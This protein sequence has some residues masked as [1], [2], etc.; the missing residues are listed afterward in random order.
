MLFVGVPVFAGAMALSATGALG[1]YQPTQPLPPE[2]FVDMHCHVAGIGAGGSGCFVSPRMRRSFRFGFF[3]RSFGVT[4]AEVESRG[5]DIIVERLAARLA[6]SRHVGRAVVLALDGAVDAHGEIDRTRTEMYV[7]NEFV[8]A[9]AARH[10]NL[11]FGASVNP[12]RPDAL[13]RLAWAK[14][15][16][17]VLVKWLPS[18][19]HIDPADARLIPFYDRLAALRLP[20]L[21]HT[22]S[23]HSFTRADD[24]L[25]DPER[26]RLPLSRGVVVI[27]AHA[28]TVGWFG[29][30]RSIDRIARVMREYPNLYADISSLTQLNKH[31]HLR[32]V[33]RR[34]EFRGRLLYGSDYPLIAMP[35]LVS[36]HHYA[37]RLSWRRRHAIACTENPWDRDIGLKQALGVP[38][39]VWTASDALLPPPAGATTDHPTERPGLGG[40]PGRPPHGP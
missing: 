14:A 21:T 19:Q 10:P 32:R 40:P 39:E 28:G 20:L 4:L 3:L 34:P 7:P 11:L 1:S 18:I 6:E 38:A 2:K 9:A 35:L 26:L 12:Y 36:P 24:A 29:G 25:C 15:H 5:D 8:A 23:E 22:G 31:D 17:A 30:E 13:E 16:D 37:F 33:L 27:A